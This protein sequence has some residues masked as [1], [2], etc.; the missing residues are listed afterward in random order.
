[1]THMG[2]DYGELSCAVHCVCVAGTED[3]ALCYNECNN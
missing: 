2:Q 3:A 1:M